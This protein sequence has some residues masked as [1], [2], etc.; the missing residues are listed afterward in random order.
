MLGDGTIVYTR[1]VLHILNNMGGRW[2]IDIEFAGRYGLMPNPGFRPG[3]RQPRYTAAEDPTRSIDRLSQRTIG[4]ARRLI[5][6]LSGALPIQY[7]HPHGQFTPGKARTCPGP[8]I[9]MNIGD[10]ACE[11]LGLQYERQ[12]RR[13]RSGEID[14][15]QRNYGYLQKF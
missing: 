7:I 11:N 8:D 10:W 2:G 12:D 4:S 3:S 5:R 9:W 15:Q 1:D 13:Y 14:P 6:F